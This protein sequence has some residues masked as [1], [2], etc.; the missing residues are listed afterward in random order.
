[1]VKYEFSSKSTESRL[2]SRE[3]NGPGPG[4][5]DIITSMVKPTFNKGVRKPKLPSE[6]KPSSQNEARRQRASEFDLESRIQDANI[7]TVNNVNSRGERIPH[8]VDGSVGQ[9]EVS[10][11]SDRN[12]RRRTSSN[13]SATKST[14][15]QTLYRGNILHEQRKK[16]ASILRS[17]VEENNKKLRVPVVQILAALEKVKLFAVLELRIT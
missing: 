4:K 15:K 3:V 9:L 10:I 8:T 11:D 6:L 2:P 7:R 12:D 5:Y 1:M 14:V 17:L 13:G 16:A